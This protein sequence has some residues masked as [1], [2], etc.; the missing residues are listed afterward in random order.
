[1][2]ISRSRIRC[3]VCFFPLCLILQAKRNEVATWD[4]HKTRFGDPKVIGKLMCIKHGPTTINRALWLQ[5]QNHI[6]MQNNTTH[7]ELL[8]IRFWVL[9]LDSGV[10]L[11]EK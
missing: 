10:V 9:Q 2:A 1:M 7:T 11:W 3:W 4:G 5:A 8:S 6:E